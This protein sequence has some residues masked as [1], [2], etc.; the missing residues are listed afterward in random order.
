[1]ASSARAFSNS[2]SFLR[3]DKRIN[4]CGRSIGNVRLI[5]K[6]AVA[7]RCS[8]KKVFLKISQNS[9]E[10]ICARVCWPNTSGGYFC[11]YQ[12]TVGLIQRCFEK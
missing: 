1:M 11:Q 10:D 4:S 5:S 12:I 8:V 6:E 2:K 7:Q 9:Q 3:S